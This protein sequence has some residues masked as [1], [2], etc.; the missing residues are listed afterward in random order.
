MW[1][2]RPV[3][4]TNWH[5]FGKKNE[6]SEGGTTYQVVNK[7]EETNEAFAKGRL[8]DLFSRLPILVLND[9]GHHCWREAPTEDDEKLI[10][11]TAEIQSTFW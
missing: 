11:K 7:G 1:I 2:F 5:V 6:H 4:V 8:G 10:H 9:E 3:L